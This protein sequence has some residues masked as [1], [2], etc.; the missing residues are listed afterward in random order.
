MPPLRAFEGMTA[1]QRKRQAYKTNSS[2]DIW[3]GQWK[4]LQRM[5]KV[6]QKKKG[7]ENNPHKGWRKVHAEVDLMV[8]IGILAKL[9]KE[10]N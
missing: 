5:A 7:T 2:Q 4:P 3:R 1:S 6:H 8:K 9:I 10:I